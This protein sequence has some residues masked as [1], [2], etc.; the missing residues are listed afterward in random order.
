MLLKYGDK[1]MMSL[2]DLK[3]RLS[4]AVFD[5]NMCICDLIVGSYTCYCL[6]SLENNMVEYFLMRIDNEYY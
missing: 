3:V 6:I 5:L 4:V 2:G 1:V